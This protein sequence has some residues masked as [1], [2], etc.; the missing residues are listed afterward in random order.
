MRR[1]IIRSQRGHNYV[2]KRLLT[3]SA[4]DCY[5]PMITQEVKALHD[6]FLFVN[7]GKKRNQIGGRIF[8]SKAVILLCEW[9]HNR[10]AD[11][12]SN[13]IYD[14]KRS[15][16]DEQIESYFDE[17]RKDKVEVPEYVYEVHTL[18][19]KRMGKTKVDFF[20]EEEAALVNKQES[21]FDIQDFN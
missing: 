16:T 4:E 2:W 9:K 11:I 15:I 21:L 20:E 3:V 14:K 8:I 6:S 7:K 1:V 13:Y 18:K 10:D 17:V 19:G 5:G 12:L